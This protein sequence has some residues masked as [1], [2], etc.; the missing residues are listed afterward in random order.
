M[1][2]GSAIA[3]IVTMAFVHAKTEEKAKSVGPVKKDIK[4]T[5]PVKKDVKIGKEKVQKMG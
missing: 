5:E 3:L 4:I 2:F 1:R